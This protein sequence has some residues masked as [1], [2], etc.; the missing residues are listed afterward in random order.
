MDI[1]NKRISWSWYSG[2]TTI[3]SDDKK[4]TDALKAK[5]TA[6]LA[7]DEAKKE[8]LSLTEAEKEIGMNG[9]SSTQ[10]DEINEAQR[11]KT[12]VDNYFAKKKVYDDANTT[13]LNI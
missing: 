13:L 6:K 3:T 11:L 12:I 5:E 8:Y 1:S 7:Y 4:L 10:Q 9:T 2:V